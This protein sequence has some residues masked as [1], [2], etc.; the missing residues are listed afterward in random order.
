MRR[1]SGLDQR[2]FATK[3]GVSHSAI[4]NWEQGKR[5]PKAD[6]FIAMM[7][8]AYPAMSVVIDEMTSPWMSR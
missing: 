3:Y 2:K 7:K 6:V 5:T 8:D 4:Y 1:L